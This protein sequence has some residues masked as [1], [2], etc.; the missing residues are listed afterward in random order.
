MY[1]YQEKENFEELIIR[2]ADANS[3]L[4]YELVEKDYF[5]SLVLQKIH[6]LIP[7]VVFKGGTSLSKAYKIISRFSEDVDIAYVTEDHKRPSVGQRRAVQKS[8]RLIIEELGLNL[9]NEEQIK[10]RSKQHHNVFR[11]NYHP[12]EISETLK[13]ML[14]IETYFYNSSFP[15]IELPITN[16]IHDYLV[17]NDLTDLV[18]SY[19]ELKPFSMNVQS[20][21]RTYI[22]KVFAASDRF[23]KNDATYN[24][25]HLFDL[26]SIYNS[27]QLSVK[28]EL[29]Y[30]T[31]D[32]IQKMLEEEV[33]WNPSAAPGFGI[34]D[35]FKKMFESDFFEEDYEIVTTRIATNPP[36][37]KRVKEVV[38]E[39]I[40]EMNIPKY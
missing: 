30:N 4:S 6:E 34:K 18:E 32:E 35:N 26:Y 29:F 28:S 9:T 27:G 33:D 5:V 1:I 13:D 15:V 38:G 2:V 22:D 36:S 25:R 11:I 14:L 20:L 12:K 3:E 16:Y 23:M 21:E 31:F 24:S 7:E 10:S 8:L 17:D 19:P 40:S 39:A 37:Y